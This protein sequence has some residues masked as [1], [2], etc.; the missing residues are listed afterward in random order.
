[1]QAVKVHTL[2]LFPAPLGFL[3]PYTYIYDAKWEHDAALADENYTEY[4][5]THKLR[6]AANSESLKL[7]CPTPL[8]PPPHITLIVFGVAMVMIPTQAAMKADSKV[9]KP[10]L[11][12]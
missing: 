7:K 8:P 10:M 5:A 4:K 11:R 6:L 9:T 12:R 2:P 1:M 3:T